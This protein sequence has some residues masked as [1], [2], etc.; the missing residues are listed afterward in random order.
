MDAELREHHV[1]PNSLQG[2]YG[3]P[4]SEGMGDES[5]QRALS[6]LDRLHQQMGIQPRMN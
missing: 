6:E 2:R 1:D 3:S 4:G 5:W